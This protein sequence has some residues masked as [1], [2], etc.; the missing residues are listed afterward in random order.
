VWY[1]DKAEVPAFRVGLTVPTWKGGTFHHISY[2]EGRYAIENGRCR[3][4]RL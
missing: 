1:G 3:D 2:R 4:H